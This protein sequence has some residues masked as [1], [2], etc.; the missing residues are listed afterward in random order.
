M[1]FYT[2]NKKAQ[3]NEHK[4]NNVLKYSG[5][6]KIVSFS[7]NNYQQVSQQLFDPTNFSL[8]LLIGHAN[9]PFDFRKV[10][11]SLTFEYHRA[12][13][14]VVMEFFVRRYLVKNQ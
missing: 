9:A 2:K 14:Y 5:D 1:F 7:S 12:F 13:K 10:E 11:I 8:E 4:A 6:K 3:V